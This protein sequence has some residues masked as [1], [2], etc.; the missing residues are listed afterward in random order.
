M[1]RIV[2]IT[3]LLLGV[4]GCNNVQS[5]DLTG[6]WVM[7]DASR[8]IL[9]DRLRNASAKIVLSPDG[10]FFASEMPGLFYVPERR[11]IR[12]ESGSGGWKLVA[13]E[14][15]QQV[16]LD[17]QAITDWSKTELPYGTQLDV[18]KVG[19]V[20]KLFYFVG[21]ADTGQRIEFEKK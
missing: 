2:L 15:G 19:S 11:A 17:F 21:D 10:S 9:P 20:A 16:Q 13:R 12:L 8:Q 6:S 7:T 4:L 14:G 18:S 3:Y 5:S 1:L